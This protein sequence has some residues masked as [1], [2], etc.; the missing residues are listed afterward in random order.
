[1]I[2]RK[3]EHGATMANACIL[4]PIVQDDHASIF[5]GLSHPHVVRHYGV[6]FDTLEAAQEQMDWYTRLEREGT[7]KWWAIR[8]TDGAVFFGAIGVNG[9][10]PTHRKGE[11]GFWLLPEHWGQGLIY[12]V[13]PLVLEHAFGAL[14]LH[15]LEAQVEPEN[16][17]SR[18]VLEK[19]GFRYEGTLREC[20]LKDGRFLS[21]DILSLLATER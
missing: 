18:R 11:I 15:R 13:L 2:C 20:E 3:T 5:R 7:G 21:L 4:S 14:G 16:P 19:V 6:R 8:S 9:I 12:S 17:A 10:I 1:M